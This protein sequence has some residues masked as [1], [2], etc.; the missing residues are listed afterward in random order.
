MLRFCNGDDGSKWRGVRAGRA[1]ARRRVYPFGRRR[2]L[3]RCRR[4]AGLP[5]ATAKD[6]IAAALD[7]YILE[8]QS[9]QDAD[10]A[11]EIR[12]CV[13]GVVD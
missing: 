11:T 10:L 9:G 13:D 7:H 4:D 3:E 1:S 12:E 5:S 2:G 6:D 8:V